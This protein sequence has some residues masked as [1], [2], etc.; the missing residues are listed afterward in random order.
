MSDFQNS[1]VQQ[2]VLLGKESPRGSDRPIRCRDLGSSNYTANKRL[3]ICILY[4][5]PRFKDQNML[6]NKW[7][8]N[9][10]VLKLM[11]PSGGGSN[12][13]RDKFIWVKEGRA[14]GKHPRLHK[15]KSKMRRKVFQSVSF[16]LTGKLVGRKNTH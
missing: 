8:R 10:T 3:S 15:K 7:C 4:S 5:K 11:R 1:A 13:L 14:G 6:L 9:G 2:N 12:V 16:S